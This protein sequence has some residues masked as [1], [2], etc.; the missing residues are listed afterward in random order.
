MRKHEHEKKFINFEGKPILYINKSLV[1]LNQGAGFGEVALMS[2]E[3]RMASVRTVGEECVLATLTRQDFK[4][5]L[6]RAQNRKFMHEVMFLK[7]FTLFRNLTNMKLQK[8]FYLL[9]LSEQ[10]RG[11]VLFR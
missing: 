8:L 5:V 11:A 1:V 7:S 10:P 9:R 4:N 6:K 2:D 3:P